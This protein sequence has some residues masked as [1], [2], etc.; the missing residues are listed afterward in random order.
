MKILAGFIEDGKHS[1]IDRYLLNFLSVAQEN[2][3]EVDFLTSVYD[4]ALAKT[5]AEKGSRLWAI[6]NLKKPLAQYRTVKKIVREGGYD[7]FYAN[8]S[9]ALNCP[10]AFAAKR[11]GIRVIL[12]SHSSG[13]DRANALSRAVRSFLNRVCRLFLY[14]AGDRYFACSEK[15]ALWLFPEKVLHSPD[16]T[17]IYNA[18]S[19]DKFA[20]S[21]EKRK[22][23]RRELG[24][25][26]KKMLL[27]V[28]HFCYQKNNFF[29]L[30]FLKVL[31]KKE[32]E[33][34]L[35]CAGTG[36]DLEAFRARAREMG[37]AD[38]VFLLGV[39]QDVEALFSAGDVFLLPSRFEGLPLVAVEAQTSGIP[40][41][42]SDRI[43]KLCALSQNI[44]FLPENAA[45]WA[46]ATG[47][48]LALPRGAAKIPAEEKQKFDLTEQ[49][50]QFTEKVFSWQLPKH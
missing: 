31:L 34:V 30:E 12:H 44:E 4:E 45:L 29:L 11:Q 36:P 16:F 24:I 25:E 42:V 3:V 10:A 17:L 33:A 41:L 28:G 27:F 18:V 15:A 1:G 6:P 21:E 40:C 47:K 49:K 2:G 9:E 32:P 43:T 37:L 14:R 20:F 50:Q 23:I 48:A 19:F 8:I 35:V 38:R 13:V 39:R 26:N 22:A 5:L 7:L 46:E